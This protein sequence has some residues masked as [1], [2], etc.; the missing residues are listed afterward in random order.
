MNGHG[1]W[2][3]VELREKGGVK[4]GEGGDGRVEGATGLGKGQEGGDVEPLEDGPLQLGRQLAE[5][6]RTIAGRRGACVVCRRPLR[7]DGLPHTFSRNRG[8]L[9]VEPSHDHRSRRVVLARSFDPFAPFASL[10]PLR[11][12]Q[13]LRYLIFNYL[14]F[15]LFIIYFFCSFTF[16]D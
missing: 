7:K 4:G 2:C 13:R 9:P 12:H 11:P 16:F 8:G 3:V 10:A 14:L 6:P 15:Y 5:L 1:T